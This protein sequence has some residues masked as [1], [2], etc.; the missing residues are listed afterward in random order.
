MEV[1]YAQDDPII[2]EGIAQV[3]EKYS[4]HL[5][6]RVDDRGSQLL[7]GSRSLVVYTHCANPDHGPCQWQYWA[8]KYLGKW[9]VIEAGRFMQMTLASCYRLLESEELQK[10]RA[11]PALG[12]SLSSL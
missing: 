3:L 11:A 4:D 7:A 5:V 6:E 9:H 12:G 8:I 1:T 2:A 10:E